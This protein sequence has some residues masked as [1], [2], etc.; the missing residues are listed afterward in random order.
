M[1]EFEFVVSDPIGIHK[2]FENLQIL[3]NNVQ[4]EE[5]QFEI[6]GDSYQFNKGRIYHSTLT[7]E[8]VEDRFAEA[9]KFTSELIDIQYDVDVTN[10]TEDPVYNKPTLVASSIKPFRN[11]SR[12]NDRGFA[13]YARIKKEPITGQYHIV[14]PQECRNQETNG[15]ILGNIKYREDS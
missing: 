2:I 7:K 11:A 13:I 1:F 5:L 8:D 10:N 4:P 14:I 9:R 15:V 12:L 3:S 6:I